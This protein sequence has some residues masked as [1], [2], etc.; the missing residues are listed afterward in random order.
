MADEKLELISDA[1][2]FTCINIIDFS[3]SFT[4]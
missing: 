4:N 3:E 2:C 1:M